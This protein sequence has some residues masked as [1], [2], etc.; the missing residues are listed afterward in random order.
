MTHH[1]LLRKLNDV[2]FKPFRIRLSNSSAIDVVNAGS[3]IVGESSGDVV[4]DAHKERAI[5]GYQ[6]AVD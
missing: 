1:D 6:I 5:C 2:P 4:Q 3:I